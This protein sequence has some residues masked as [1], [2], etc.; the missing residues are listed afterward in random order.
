VKAI[1]GIGDSLPQSLQRFFLRLTEVPE[2]MAV[3]PYDIRETIK[4]TSATD[5]LAGNA[6]RDGILAGSQIRRQPQH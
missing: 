5:L 1:L 2:I 4:H 3:L 6:H